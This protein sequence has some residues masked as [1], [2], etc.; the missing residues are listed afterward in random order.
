MKISTNREDLLPPL[1]QVGSV[2]ERRQTLPILANVLI[3]VQKGSITFTATDLEVE[4]KTTIKAVS[5]DEMEF[6]LPARKL[7]DICK[8]LPEGADIELSVEGEK[9]TLRSGRGRYKLGMLPAVDYPGIE[10]AKASQSFTIIEKDFRQ[11]LGKTQFAM[12]QQDVRYYLNGM[13]LEA[14]QDLLRAVATDGHR[15]AMCEWRFPI[16]RKLMCK[17]FCRERPFS[18]CTDY[19]PIQIKKFGLK[20]VPA[21]CRFTW[22]TPVLLRN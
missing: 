8:A 10:P 21:I 17:L 7:I 4:L 5:E 2:V 12:A 11:V 1:L 15:L 18:N 22:K 9:A 16:D 3:S 20:S 19:W 14:K 6:T 13:L